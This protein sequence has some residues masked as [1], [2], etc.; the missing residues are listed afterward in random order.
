MSQRMVA[1]TVYSC[2]ISHGEIYQLL[3]SFLKDAPQVSQSDQAVLEKMILNNSG[4]Q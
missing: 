2:D 4:K 1:V 3:L